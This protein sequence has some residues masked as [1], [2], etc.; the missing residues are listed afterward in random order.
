[1]SSL[2]E[3]VIWDQFA[4]LRASL[5]QPVEVLRAK[6][7]VF[8][9]CGTSYYLAQ[10]IAAA[11]ND[12]GQ[13]AIAVPAAEWTDRPGS[14]LA[15][16]EGAV[17]VG[18]SRSGTTTETIEALRV[19]RELGLSTIALSCE[20]DSTILQVAE[21]GI[22]LPTDKREGIVMT[23]SA[24]L[25]LLAGLRMAGVPVTEAN[26]ADAERVL[27][28]ISKVADKAVAGRRHFVT[29]GAGALYGIANE[30][31]LKLQEMSL[32]ISQAFHPL[33][34]RHGPIS[35]VDGVSMIVLLYSSLTQAREEKVAQ[36]VSAKGAFV[37]GIGGR[38]DV[39]IDVSTQ[40]PAR[41][42]AVLPALQLLG[43]KV[44][45]A[46]NLDTETPRHLTKVVVLN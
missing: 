17:V 46:K 29:L 30:A 9:G 10:A 19:S 16:L 13:N 21:R 35:L 33:E 8:V 42:L 25:M 34:Y 39:K 4:Y 6:T 26:I 1:M 2:T 14:Y 23:V 38:G 11:T 44:A 18:L 41:A 12:A 43:E 36:D 37:V 27:S 5:K 40:G 31:S 22:H 3:Q 7:V 32:S 20:P 24:S 45:C 28:A 15:D